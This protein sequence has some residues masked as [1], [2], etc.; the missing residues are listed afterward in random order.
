MFVDASH[1]P[2]S[3]IVLFEGL[4][5]EPVVNTGDFRL[6]EGLQCSPALQRVASARCVHLF[7]DVSCAHP[8]LADVPTKRY[9]LAM[10]FDLLDRHPAE[11]VLLHSHGLCDDQLLIAVARYFPGETL[12]FAAEGRLWQ[13]QPTHGSFR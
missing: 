6:H 1:C 13:L 7:L 3:V 5:G 11:N 2:G 10:I 4:P 12:R 8:A 9:S